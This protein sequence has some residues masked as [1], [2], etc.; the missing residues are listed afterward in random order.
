MLPSFMHNIAI[1][2]VEMILMS[3]YCLSLTFVCTIR[4]RVMLL[5]NCS[6]VVILTRME[7]KQSWNEICG[8]GRT[9]MLEFHHKCDSRLFIRYIR[10]IASKPCSS[11]TLLIA[12]LVLWMG[13]AEAVTVERHSARTCV[14]FSNE[15]DHY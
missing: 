11:N 6:C 10:Y 4:S 2:L 13:L 9:S 1:R 12:D 5:L 3:L 7:Y 15:S 8:E 14:Y